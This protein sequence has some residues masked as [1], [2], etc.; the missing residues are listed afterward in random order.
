MA[1]ENDLLASL[2][3]SSK[4][5]ILNPHNPVFGRPSLKGSSP[6]LKEETGG[7]D[8]DWVPT[9]PVSAFA[10]LAK[11]TSETEDLLRPQ[12]FF[13]PEKTTGLEGMLE[14]ARIQDDLM[15]VDAPYTTQPWSNERLPTSMRHL[16]EWRVTFVF[17][18]AAFVVSFIFAQQ[19]TWSWQT[20]S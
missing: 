19:M 8:M 4:P 10:G 1:S 17:S 3:L 7:E 13:A 20:K 2:S 9:N 6:V 5:V 14:C 12:R 18:L 11:F 16:W 15:V